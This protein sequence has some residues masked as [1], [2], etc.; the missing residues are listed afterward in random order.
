MCQT[1]KNQIDGY[2]Y[3]Q[4]CGH[5]GLPRVETGTSAICKCHLIEDNFRENKGWVC[6]VCGAGNSPLLTTCPCKIGF[7]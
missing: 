5:C 2:I 3:T 7:Y 4:Y 6:P 1:N